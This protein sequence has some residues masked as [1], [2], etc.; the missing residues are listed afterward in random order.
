MGW[1]GFNSI[2]FLIR[3]VSS[4]S[5]PFQ[6]ILNSPYCHLYVRLIRNVFWGKL[7]GNK[8]QK[9]EAQEG[10]EKVKTYLRQSLPLLG[11]LVGLGFV[12]LNLSLDREYLF[13]GFS[14]QLGR[15]L[16]ILHSLFN[17]IFHFI[18]Y[19]NNTSQLKFN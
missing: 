6:R 16:F 3:R 18:F 11:L 2:F 14:S 4:W 1:E 12:N 15:S 13:L 19:F 17:L 9:M 5:N 7:G 8:N 10:T